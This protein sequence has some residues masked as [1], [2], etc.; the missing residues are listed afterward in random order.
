MDYTSKEALDRFKNALVKRGYTLVKTK[1][2]EY[3]YKPIFRYYPDDRAVCKLIVNLYDTSQYGVPYAWTYE[4]VVLI[5]RTTDELSTSTSATPSAPSTSASSWPD[6]SCI[7]LTTPSTLP[8]INRHS[9]RQSSRQG[10]GCAM[11]HS[12]Q[13]PV[14]KICHTVTRIC[15]TVTKICHGRQNDQYNNPKKIHQKQ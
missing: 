8:R 13:R 15:H 6:S 10:F 9:S 3:Y 11:M 1:D 7:L 5:S 12:I 2:M 14:T 4:P